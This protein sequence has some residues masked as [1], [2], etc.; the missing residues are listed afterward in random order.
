MS[1]KSPNLAQEQDTSGHVNVVQPRIF[2]RVWHRGLPICQKCPLLSLSK[3]PQ[4]RDTPS[5]VRIS[6]RFLSWARRISRAIKTS[7]PRRKVKE[8]MAHTLDLASA[9]QSGFKTWRV[10]NVSFGAKRSAESTRICDP[11][12][13][14]R[15]LAA[16]S[17]WH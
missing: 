13:G 15:P 8:G 7:R 1:G 4:F 16:V 5:Q 14:R 2:T 17:F 11:T 6:Q 9:W 12:A 3:S 10:Q